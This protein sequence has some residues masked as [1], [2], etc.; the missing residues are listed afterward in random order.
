[1]TEILDLELLRTFL[2]VTESGS[3]TRAGQRLNRVQTMNC[4]TF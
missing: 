3:F 1:M 4:L 2:E